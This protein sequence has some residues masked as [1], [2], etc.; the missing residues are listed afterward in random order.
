MPSTLPAGWFECNGQAVT[1]TYLTAT[2][3]L[4]GTTDTD[5]RFLRGSTTSGST[6]GSS[7][8]SHIVASGQLNISTLSYAH[9]SGANAGNLITG[10]GTILSGG[11]SGVLSIEI[12]ANALGASALP[13]Y[14]D[15]VYIIKGEA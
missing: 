8:H 1:A 5:R 2:P 4:N 6:G 15:V 14:Y 7:I 3:D 9:W 10:D 12:Q 11:G 13:P